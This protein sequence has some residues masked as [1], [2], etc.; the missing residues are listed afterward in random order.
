MVDLPPLSAVVGGQWRPGIGDP[1][2]MGWITVAAYFA[3]AALCGR[4]AFEKRST[5]GR[6]RGRPATF[7]LVLAG[8]M[9]LLGVNKQLDLQ[10]LLTEVGRRVLEGASLYGERRAYQVA[11]IRAVIAA[12]LASVGW[13]CWAARRSPRD[14]WL[15]TIGVGFVMGFVAIRACSFHN[16][17]ALLASRLGGLKWNWIF[18]LGGISAVAASACLARLRSRGDRPPGDLKESLR[19]V[20]RFRSK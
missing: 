17:D 20:S 8:L 9:A 12:C 7:W 6:R 16:V 14:R 1:T 10:S 19:A 4:A 11:F 15:A 13:A 18:E 5:A 3:S 2:V